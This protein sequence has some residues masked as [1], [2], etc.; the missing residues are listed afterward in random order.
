MGT[1]H[2][3]G[4][5]RLVHVLAEGGR[6]RGIDSAA[7]AFMEDGLYRQTFEE[8][9]IPTRFFDKDPG[10]APLLPLR[11]AAA[12]REF[13]A[14]ILHAHHFGPYVY[15]VGAAKILGIPLVYTEHSREFY[16]SPRRRLIGRSMSK[17]ATVVSVS[18]E[19]DEWRRREFGYS[20]RVILNG[21]PVPP[22]P[23]PDERQSARIRLGIPADAPTLGAVA[24][25]MPEKDHATMLKAFEI[26]SRFVNDAHLIL[27]GSGPK[28]GTIQTLA[29]ELGV[30]DRVHFLGRRLDVDRILPALDVITLSSTRE[31]L[32]LAL[33]EGMAAGAA[34]IATDVG[35][36]GQLIGEE[37]GRTVPH[38]DPEA[39]GAAYAAV[40]SNPDRLATAKLA[41]RARIIERYSSDA[42]IDAYAALYRSACAE[43]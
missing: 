37:C 13:D 24:R 10:P 32:P 22:L 30:A 7:F 38:S 31:G 41:S 8:S 3:G 6:T 16:T 1:F 20:T 5:E 27:V 11:L 28:L 36:I 35:E 39:L 18:D 43:K 4:L 26:L 19:L 42:M 34:A 12:A 29:A 21:V 23:T 25:F 15:A 40:L 17:A 9:S 2:I 33:L 14:D